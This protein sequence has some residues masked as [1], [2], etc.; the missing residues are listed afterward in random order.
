M[1]TLNKRLKEIVFK[2][3]K[4]R[5]KKE[6]VFYEDVL[7]VEKQ[8][9]KYWKNNEYTIVGFEQKI[10]NK[11]FTPYEWELAQLV[12]K[13]YESGLGIRNYY[14]AYLDL[15]F[16]TMIGFLEGVS[17]VA[18]KDIDPN[19]VHAEEKYRVPKIR[20]YVESINRIKYIGGI[21]DNP[22]GNIVSLIIIGEHM[23]NIP[24]KQKHLKRW[25]LSLKEEQ[26]LKGV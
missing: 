13:T 2:E 4:H 3:I 12:V 1:V 15:K 21:K 26:I 24:D 14:D 18:V 8:Q 22:T 25:I 5:Y 6:R 17:R 7:K 20:I 23:D 9:W 10:I 11:L 19:Q 16:D